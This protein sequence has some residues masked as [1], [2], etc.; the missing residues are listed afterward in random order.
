M[1]LLVGMTMMLFVLTHLLP[2]DPVRI[3]LGQ[4]ATPEQ[5]RAYREE[6]ELNDPLWRQY[7]RYIG[8]L[9]RGNF[10]TSIISRRPVT[11]D[12]SAHLP[13][14][15]ELAITSIGF[16]TLVSVPL[17]IFSAVRR[18]EAVDQ[19]AQV[20]SLFTISMPVFWFG[21]LLQVAFYVN[22]GWLP[23]S[24]R[25]GS[26]VLPPPHITGLYTL[27]SLLEGR[28]GTF[29][30]ALKHL[31][32]PAIALSNINLAVLTRI[33]RS[34]MLDVLNEQ[35]LTTARAKGLS[36][37]AVIWRHALRN[38]LVPIATLAGL[39]FGDLVAGAILTETIFAWPGIGQYAV[40]SIERVDYPALIGFAIV[41]TLGYFFV[42]LATDIFYL[43]VDPRIRA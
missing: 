30:D 20:V 1:P 2:A 26:S 3:A 38:A 19:V 8:Q 10:G 15:L 34:S 7:L 24:G 14:T 18:G 9:A 6:L 41:V 33:T 35:Y 40:F 11:K 42:N 4:D 16:S 28:W 23:A 36:D 37:R 5:V 27:D 22:L 31:I 29:V 25:L 13:A 39:R 32:L 21:V 43:V 17:G 12:L